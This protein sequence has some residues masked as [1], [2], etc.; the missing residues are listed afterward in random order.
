MRDYNDLD[1][2]VPM[3]SGLASLPR[4]LAPPPY[5]MIASGSMRDFIRSKTDLQALAD[6]LCAVDFA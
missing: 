2:L 6:M 5:R 4:C 1:G 3:M